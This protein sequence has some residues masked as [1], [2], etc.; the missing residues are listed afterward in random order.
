MTAT[1]DTAPDRTRRCS[2]CSTGSSSSC[3]TP[4]CPVSLT[5]NLD[6]M[7]AVQ[8]IPIEDR[9]AFKYALGATLIK[10]NAHWRAF[11]TV[12]EVYF[13]L[14]GPEYRI[15]EGDETRLDEMWREMQEQQRRARAAAR[16]AAA[17]DSLT[18]EEIAH[19]LMQA[20]LNGDQAMMRALARQAVQRFAGME[21]GPPGRRHVLPVPHAA[22]PRP[23][24]HAREADG[25]DPRAGRRRADVA[26]GA[27]RARGVPGPHREVQ[28]RDRGR[29][30]PPAGRRPRRRGD[31][32]DA[33][34]AAARGRR[35]HARLARRD[36]VAAEGAVPADPQA[37][38]PPG[39]Q[40]PPRPQGPARLPQHGAPLA[41]AT[42][43]CRPSRSSSTRARP[44][45]S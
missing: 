2:T 44:S 32:Q 45:R 34:Q 27:P 35:V 41:V 43:A 37:R 9:E 40:A 11:E 5:E 36:A 38:R 39:P 25:G 18:P 31:G 8:H 4:G 22:Q 28:G 3:A 21:P 15:A 6:A 26:R 23:R 33:A 13:S 10:N 42:A 14:R 20:L 19:L 17:M 30:P 7:E 1:T 24:R 29:D 16:P 12:F